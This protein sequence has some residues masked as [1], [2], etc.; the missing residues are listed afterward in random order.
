MPVVATMLMGGLFKSAANEGLAQMFEQVA[1]VLRGGATKP[2][3]R[4]NR[5]PAAPLPDPFSVWADMVQ[6]MWARA[7]AKRPESKPE[8]APLDQPPNPFATWADMISAM[9]GGARDREP[10]SKPKPAPPK[11]KNPF[12]FFG[13]MFETGRQ[14]QQQQLATLQTIFDT[15]WPPADS[16]RR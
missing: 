16:R 2:E 12:E 6:G 15:Y 8:R 13:C 5:E 4:R 9:A 10:E 7:P 14:A 11:L 1:Q 3:I